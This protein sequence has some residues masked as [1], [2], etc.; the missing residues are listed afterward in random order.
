MCE[1]EK[2]NPGSGQAS[3]VVATDDTIT[4]DGTSGDPLKVASPFT[5]DEKTK[6]A[7]IADNAAA[8]SGETLFGAVD[9]VAADGA[10]KDTWWNT[11]AV[12]AT[13]WKKAAGAWTK[14]LTLPAA[15][16]VVVVD[17]DNFVGWSDDRVI[18]DADFDTAVDFDSDT[19][20]LGAQA[21]AAYIWFG[22]RESLDDPT[23]LIIGANPADQLGFY[24]KLAGTVTR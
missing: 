20:V 9:P 23:S 5:A 24:Q 2:G 4:G 15:G 19:A 8:Y 14:M 7:A 22:R 1:G 11:T 3:G 10:N 18:A 17:H 16:G 21:T 13:L 12:P 6:L